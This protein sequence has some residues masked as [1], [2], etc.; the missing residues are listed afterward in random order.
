MNNLLPGLHL[1]AATVWIV[2]ALL[3][4]P[5]EGAAYAVLAAVA[6]VRCRAFVGMLSVHPR[7]RF[8]VVTYA[9][10][11][12]W[13]FL[14]MAWSP[15]GAE[16]KVY[17]R[18][19]IVP[20]FV[21]HAGLTR[22]AMARILFWPGAIWSVILVAAW[23]GIP[24]PSLI[25]PDHPSKTVLG[26]VM[27]G[28]VA[29]SGAFDWKA[30]R[31]WSHWC[32]KIPTW[33]AGAAVAGSR[34]GVVAVLSGSLLGFALTRRS[35]RHTLRTIMPL[36]VVFVVIAGALG[37]TPVGK[38]A[39]AYLP[40]LTD[41]SAVTRSIADR[42]DKTLSSRLALWDWTMT[43]CSHVFVGHGALSWPRDFQAAMTEKKP[44]LTIVTSI[45]PGAESLNHAH[46]I[47][48]QMMY[49]QGLIGVALLIGFAAAVG[50]L[51]WNRR[52]TASG[53]LLIVVGLAIAIMSLTEGALLTR[54]SAA[55]FTILIGLC[56]VDST[57]PELR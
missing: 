31:S 28:C 1:W 55:M 35:I 19:M 6:L 43:A 41:T 40:S 27:L 10:V 39:L 2:G 25:I 38:K 54:S 44:R 56:S 36:A 18:I 57:A 13:A 32:L 15:D 30:V 53:A 48:I 21:V 42:L 47:L 49:E 16:G 9:A 17:A 51:A 5:L 20:I 3:A 37:F 26:L 14:S 24:V 22:E 46:S 8:V 12:F 33:F 23:L 4:P 45:N 11:L 50:N 7:L 29:F 52:D 34:T